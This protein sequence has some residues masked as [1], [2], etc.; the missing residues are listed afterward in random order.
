M[1]PIMLFIAAIGGLT[2]GLATVYLVISLPATI[3]W[4]LYRRI[5]K[6]I[7]VTK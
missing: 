3:L 5:V 4:K 1:N 6:G 2:G 7:P